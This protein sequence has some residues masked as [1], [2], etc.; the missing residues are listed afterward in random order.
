[1]TA[2]APG[3]VGDSPVIGAG[4][5]ADNA[6]CAVSATG[7]GEIFIRYAA[8][9]AIA[10]RMRWAGHSVA[11]AA[12]GVVDALAPVGGSCGVI[13][14]DENGVFSMPFNCAG[15]YRGVA[16]GDGVLRTAIYQEPLAEYPSAA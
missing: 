11:A 4:T 13:A 5:W 16:T 12:R 2:K 1:M 6:S 9:H 14:V 7:H 10:A 15:M 3:R 8:A